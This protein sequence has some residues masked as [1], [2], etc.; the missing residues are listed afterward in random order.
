MSSPKLRALIVVIVSMLLSAAWV[1]A[2][3]SP[4]GN[5]AQ[6]P[7]FAVCALLAFAIQWLVFIPS[8]IKQTERFYDLTGSATYILLI[9][10]AISQLEQISISSLLL[11][12]MVVTWAARLGTFLFAR[13]RKHGRDS[14]F[15]QIKPDKYRFFS[16]WTL[17][18]LWVLITSSAALMVITSPQQADV[19]I[20]TWVG[21][22]LWLFGFVF[23]VTADTQKYR[24]KQDPNNHNKFIQSGLWAYSRHP[25]YFG[26]ILLWFG[27][28]IAA[29]PVLQ[30]WQHIALISPFFVTLLL[31]KISGIP[32]LEQSADEKWGDDPQYQLYKKNTSVLIPMR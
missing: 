2:Q 5:S 23:E 4:Q 19:S 15:D 7:T 6:L 30:G 22:A 17:Q 28:A 27:V 10:Y 11:A 13:I 26:E 31:T 16:A 21:A 9:F 14:R 3:Q 24:F 32:M 8:Y 25:N 1:C 12:G 18:G 20:L 29:F